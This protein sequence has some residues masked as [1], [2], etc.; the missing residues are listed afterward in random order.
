MKAEVQCPAGSPRS[1]SLEIRENSALILKLM[2]RRVKEEMA[3]SSESLAEIQKISLQKLENETI[4]FGKAKLGM[5]FP[6]AFKDHKWTDRFVSQY[7]KSEKASQQKFIIY[8]EKR[9]DHEAQLSPTQTLTKKMAKP[10]L[11]SRRTR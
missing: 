7:E 2:D 10:Q 11:S 8:V 4:Q 6:K 3:K 5:K 9:L 1:S